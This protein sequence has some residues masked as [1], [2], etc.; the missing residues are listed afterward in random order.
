MVD[1]LRRIIGDRERVVP[2]PSIDAKY[3]SDTL[4]RLKGQADALVFATST[5]EVAAV[6]R[7]AWENGIAVTPPRRGH[8]SGR[9]HRSPEGRHHPRPE[10]DEPCA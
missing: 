10:P 1:A 8:E 6:M 4:G 9:L 7:Y 2:G 3:L 5:Q